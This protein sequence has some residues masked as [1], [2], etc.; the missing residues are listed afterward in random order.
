MDT[1][2]VFLEWCESIDAVQQ[3]LFKKVKSP[4]IP[5]GENARSTSLDEEHADAI[6]EYLETYE[7]ASV[8]HVTWLILVETGIR[9]GGAHS[10][11]IDDYHPD[12]ETPHLQL[13]HRPDTGTSL[14]NG[15]GGERPV[16]IT[17]N[18]CC[19]IDDYLANR[20]PSVTDTHG[21]EPLLATLNG[22]I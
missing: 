8:E 12:G 21:R 7:Y 20:R 22:R 5:D 3:G 1:I 17:G 2:R 9:M 6:L 4:D 11:D 15:Q 19:V 14:K 10:L 18:A 16:G 13:I